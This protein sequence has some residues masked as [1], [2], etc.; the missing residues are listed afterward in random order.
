MNMHLSQFTCSLLVLSQA[1]LSQTQVSAIDKGINDT[2]NASLDLH[3]EEVVVTGTKTA[4]LM[5]DNPVRVEVI[6][7]ETIE[8]QHAMELSD[9][10]RTIPGLSVRPIRGKE[11]REAWLQ[12]ISANRVL[13]LVDGEPVSASTGSTID[14]TQISTSDIAKVE[15]V[16]GA[17]SVLYGSAAMG[18]VINVITH[19]PAEGLHFKLSADFGSYGD[20]NTDG[21]KHSMGRQRYNGFVSYKNDDWLVTAGI[22]SRQSDGFAVDPDDWNQQG[23]DGHK[24]NARVAVR[25]SANNDDYYQFSH[26]S[27]RQEQHTQFTE[28]KANN[29]F[30]RNKNDDAE[31]EH[32]AFKG[33][34]NLGQS[35]VTASGFYE[36][37]FNDSEPKDGFFREA[38]FDSKKGSLLWNIYDLDIHTLTIGADVFEEGLRQFT[39]T[40]EE[41]DAGNEYFEIENELDQPHVERDNVEFYIQDDIE[42]K[43]VTLVPGF[44]WQDDSGFGGKSHAEAKFT[45]GYH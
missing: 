14:L 37:Y 18:G 17:T 34:W 43:S 2:S 21:D 27:Y 32:S 36:E 20:Q 6:P 28:Y 22:N 7:Q 16:K 44:R 3:F 5:I 19:E 41:D 10:V 40:L 31:R 45:L 39:K 25:Y 1:A 13:V 9:A 11:G 4:Q 35:E 23:P 26:E 29:S 38:H 42:F 8:R 33:F 30:E 15:V 12:G 24:T